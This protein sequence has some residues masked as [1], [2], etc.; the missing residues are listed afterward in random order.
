MNIFVLNKN[1]IKSA[2][3]MVDKHVVKMPVESL[4][5]ISTCLHLRGF[6]AP[7]RMS[8]AYHPCTI[9]AREASGNYEWLYQ[10][11]LAL[12]FEYTYR[13]GKQHASYVKLHKALAKCPDNITQG[14]MTKLA[15]AMPDEYKHP[16]PIVAYRTYV[17]NEKHYAKWEKGRDKP[18]WWSHDRV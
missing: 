9:W 5:M 17:V 11:F 18:K 13:Y 6:N 8:F 16:D 4:Q 14:K 7:Y 15:Q 12:S 2:Q 3:Q 1:P 10:H